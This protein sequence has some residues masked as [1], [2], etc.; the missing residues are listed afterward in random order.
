M[1]GTLIKL[2]GLLFPGFANGNPAAAE[3]LNALQFGEL[4][5]LG[6]IIKTTGFQ[7]PGKKSFVRQHQLLYAQPIR[8]YCFFWQKKIRLP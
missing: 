4:A 2:L 7:S 3:Q 5:P 8:N 1:P 6:T